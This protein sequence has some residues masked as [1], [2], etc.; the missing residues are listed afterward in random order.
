MAAFSRTSGVNFSDCSDDHI[1]LPPDVS[2][3][4]TIRPGQTTFNVMPCFPTSR[5]IDLDIA[6]TLA[7]VP[8]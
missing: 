8:L 3:D 1:E 5:A 7:L 2:G 6:I 4:P